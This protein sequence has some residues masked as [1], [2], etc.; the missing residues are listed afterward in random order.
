MKHMMKGK[1]KCPECG[2]VI[3]ESAMVGK[4]KEA[5][6]QEWEGHKKMMGTDKGRVAVMVHMMKALPEEVEEEME[7]MKKKPKEEM[8]EEMKRRRYP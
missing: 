6:D 3:T 8:K 7:E 1:M 2:A 5:E 4:E